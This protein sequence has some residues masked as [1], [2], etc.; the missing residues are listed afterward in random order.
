[1][2]M[3]Y[4][5]THT[6]THRRGRYWAWI[7]ASS[8]SIIS[9]TSHDII[10]KYVFLF[11]VL[12][13][14]SFFLLCSFYLH[15]YVF[16][17]FIRFSSQ[18]CINIFYFY[19]QVLIYIEHNSLWASNMRLFHFSFATAHSLSLRHIHHIHILLYEKNINI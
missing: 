18:I 9:T 7:K 17:L 13:I 19:I 10:A 14:F 8:G 4:R 5:H 2:E 1:M 6:Q 16:S 11:F 12:R 3:A 15:I